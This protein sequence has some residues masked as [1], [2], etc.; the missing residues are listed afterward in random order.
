MSLSL[1][2]RVYCCFW[3]VHVLQFY[4]FDHLC[5]MVLYSVLLSVISYCSLVFFHLTHICVLLVYFLPLVLC[6]CFAVLYA[7]SVCLVLR[8]DLC[9]SCLQYNVYVPVICDFNYLTVDG[10]LFFPLVFPLRPSDLVSMFVYPLCVSSSYDLVLVSQFAICCLIS[11][12]SDCQCFVFL[13]P[14]FLLLLGFCCSS[15]SCIVP[16]LSCMY[17]SYQFLFAICHVLPNVLVSLL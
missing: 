13:L 11:I 12:V 2:H 8:W 15:T 10:R 9:L 16:S 5:I 14:L 1:E 17:M 3:D 7:H 6:S 4:I